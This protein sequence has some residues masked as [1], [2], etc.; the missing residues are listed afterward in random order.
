MFQ[1]ADFEAD[2]VAPGIGETVNFTDLSTNN[3]FDWAWTFTPS[4]VTF[5]GGTS[6]SSQNPEVQFDA[7]GNYTI[8]LTA[9]NISG[10][11]TEIKTNYIDVSIPVFDLDIKV[12][13]EGP[14]N[15]SLMNSDIGSVLPLNQPYN[16]SPWSYNGSETVI[17]IPPNV[18]DWV[19]IEVRDAAS[20]AT[21]TATTVVAK[22]AAFILNDG[23][24]VDLDGSSNLQFE[25]AISQNIFVVVW[26]RNHLGIISNDP[27][28]PSGNLLIY[29]FSTGINQVYG[30]IDGH[31]EISIGFWG[32]F[33]GDANHDG[34]VNINDMSPVWE[35]EAG[36][37]GY[38]Y[39]DHNLDGQTNNQDKDD[40]WVPNQTRSSKVPN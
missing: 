40:I 27:L 32:M 33:G 4:T 19:L 28:V 26:Q 20:A 25:A 35:N 39:S 17:F 21:A 13:L 14:F 37:Q 22:Q 16:V 1:L 30:G 7:A 9:T 15:G 23:S 2:N 5:V 12:F 29:D 6:A 34:S 38:N 36:K 3:P 11:D 31:K 8:E 10:S 18:V 24:I